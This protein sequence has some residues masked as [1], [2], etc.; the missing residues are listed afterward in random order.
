M[1]QPCE[2][3]CPDRKAGCGATCPKWEKY[4]KWRNAQ[5]EER[6]EKWDM[7]KMVFDGKIKNRRSSFNR[8]RK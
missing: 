2:K 7:D 1:K 6:K 8:R 5:Y 3:D 4:V